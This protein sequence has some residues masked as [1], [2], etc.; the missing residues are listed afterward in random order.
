MTTKRTFKLS[1]LTLAILPTISSVSVNAQEITDADVSQSEWEVI[2][3]TATRRTGTVQDTPINITALSE[4]VFRE[5]NLNELADL[6]RWV[7][8]LF[9]PDQGGRSDSPIIVRGLNTNQSG[10][11]SD[12]GT[13]SP[14]FGD[15]PLSVDVELI[16]MQRVE[17]LIGPQGTLYGAGTLGGAIRYLPNPVE[18]DSTHVEVFG[19]L[20]K[21]AQSDS[22]GGDAGFVFNTPIIDDE[23]G[24]RGSVKVVN[25][26]GFIDQPYLIREPSLSLP[27]PD[28]SDAQAVADNLR[29]EKDTNTEDLLVVRGALRWTPNDWFDGTL[30]YFH[31]T[32]ELGGRSV[33]Q[34]QS[35]ADQHPLLPVLGKYES[36]YRY[37]EP[38][39]LE[40]DLLS[41]EVSADLG[42]AELVSATGYSKS[43]RLGNRDH[44]DLLI[45]LSFGYEDFP[46]FTIFT[47][48]ASEAKHLTQE[49]RLV[50][51]NDG[52]FSW[53][54]GYYYNKSEADS[55]SYEFAPGLADFY[56][57]DRADDLEFI[58]EV[59]RDT[60]ESAFFGELN[61]AVTDKLDITLGARLYKYDIRGNA[62]AD[63]P[64]INPNFDAGGTPQRIPPDS[65]VFASVQADDTGNLFKFNISYDFTPN[66]LGYL[67]FSEGFRI[68]GAN[69][70]AKCPDP[71][72][73][74]Q[75]LCG[76]PNEL[77]YSPDTTEN[78]EL[79]IKSTWFKNK[80]HINGAL[81]NV[82]W[83]DAQVASATVNGALGITTNAAGAN[84]RGIEL[85][86]RMILSDELSA[87]A[88]YGYAKAEL[89]ARAP[90]LY[91]VLDEDFADEYDGQD[92]DRLPGSPEHQLSFGVSYSTEVFGHYQLDV[93]YGLTYQSDVITSVGLR[94]H[95]E[96]IPGFSVSNLSAVLADGD[97]SVTFFIDNLFDKYAYTSTRNSLRNIGQAVSPSGASRPAAN[98]N[99]FDLQRGYGHFILTPRTIGVEFNYM[100]DL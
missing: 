51:T 73:D 85:S 59:Y 40:D 84:S 77:L 28:F 75:N 37:E 44:T 57:I 70:V 100:F 46:A 68:G 43:N 8:G 86:T 20:S 56:D 24:F 97:W 49:L 27:D 98:S 33:T 26:P 4:D 41:L 30:T 61:Y 15:I 39:E 42:F 13:V 48:D 82:D 12:G 21:N 25:S 18:L 35:L 2:E 29:S 78:I 31:Q 71:L 81:F 50:S 3:I 65:D 7:P 83:N 67:T 45:D 19:T 62:G 1:A 99:R 88:T 32:R 10:V 23:L 47:R 22:F 14:Y 53:I 92:G 9:V 66:F 54:V 6:A 76:L 89:T 16:D 60:K 74:Q 80:L 94:N 64:L 58:D 11:G 5:Q 63:V 38:N 69:E 34:Y 93:N 72:P 87:Y 36:A 17:V 90:A 95:G 96:T 55:L 79:G 91:P 52:P